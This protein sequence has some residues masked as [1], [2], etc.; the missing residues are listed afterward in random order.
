MELEI[1]KQLGVAA[2]LA[3]LVGLE[4]QKYAQKSDKNFFAGFRTYILIGVLGVLTHV[5]YVSFPVFSYI[6]AFSFISLI[7][8]AY[9][10]SKIKENLNGLT[11]E[12]SAIIVFVNSFLLAENY[13]FIA[14]ILT[15]FLIVMLKFKESFHN[16]AK[17]ISTVEFISTL[18]FILIAFVILP[19]LP[20]VNY[21]YLDF[22]NPYVIWL[23]VVFISGISYVSY[24]LIKIFGEKNGICISGFLAGLISSTALTLS[25]SDQSKKKKMIVNP[26]V[27]SI[28]IASSAMFFR[29]IFEV[30]VVNIELLPYIIVPLVVMGG[31]GII[32]ALILFFWKSNE[33]KRSDN[34]SI[35]TENIQNPFSIWPAVKFAMFFA[36]IILMAKIADFYFGDVGIY[37]TS[38]IS[39]LLDVDAI[40]IS[41][42]TL[43][44]GNLSMNLATHAIFIASVTNTFT[45]GLIFL[46]LGNKRVAL[47]IIFIFGL[48]IASG[49]ISLAFI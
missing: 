12:I 32:S 25:F 37:F 2:I 5:L 29:V 16:W 24:F 14:T 6:I 13:Y 30:F 48:M 20:N 19:L 45:K 21:G 41:I 10:V 39:G 33:N 23:M 47:K 43:A 35:T 18:Q 40:T 28:V 27:I 1:L 49:V 26:F 34:D 42:A 7:V 8:S 46:F 3:G 38:F 17:H 36:I 11:S 9:L 15:L 4:R 44:K 31:V 22:F